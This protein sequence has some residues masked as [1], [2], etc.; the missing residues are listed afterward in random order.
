MSRPQFIAG[1]YAG[2]RADAGG[3]RRGHDDR[4][5]PRARLHGVDRSRRR[6]SAAGTRPGMDP[7]L[8]KAVFL[9]FV[10]LMLVTAIALFFSTFSTPDALGGA[11]VR[12]LHRRPFQRGLEELRSGRQLAGRRSGSRAARIT[13]CPDLSAFDVKTEVV[14]GLPV[15]AG[16][17]LATTGLRSRRTSPRCSSSR[18]SFSRGGISSERG[19]RGA[20]PWSGWRCA[21][22]AAPSR[23]RS[24]AIAAYPR[25][26]TRARA[27]S[28][29]AIG[30]RAE[31][32]DA[33]RSTR[34][35]PTS[36]GSARFS[37]TAGIGS[38]RPHGRG[39]ST[40]CCI[41]CSISRR[42]SIP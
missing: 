23:C 1:K 33:R 26:A 42:R 7:A 19:A 32:D 5:L 20:R 25:D 12:L 17:M 10:E 24:C 18:R 29:R 34:S 22:S 40:S 37:T 2:P 8:L 6:S 31:A 9:I 4:A 21:P 28:L 14:H 15:T 36:T 35:R 27:D 38:S 41:R 30:R 11:D 39:R 3:E 13:C 16:Y